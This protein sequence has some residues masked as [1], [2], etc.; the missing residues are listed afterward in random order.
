MPVQLAHGDGERAPLAQFDRDTAAEATEDGFSIRFSERWMGV[1][2]LHGGFVAATLMRTI[3]TIVADPS[4]E[5]LT[6]D[7]AYLAPTHPADAVLVTRVEK[8]GR[9]VTTVTARLLQDSRPVALAV[10]TFTTPREEHVEFCDLPLP[11][12][13]GPEAIPVVGRES[14]GLAPWADNFEMRPSL[15][16][17]AFGSSASALTGGWIKL[18]EDRPVDAA[19]LAALTDA[20]LPS[21][22]TRLGQS[23]GADATIKIGI[24]FSGLASLSASDRYGHCFIQ[25]EAP[26]ARSGYWQ[27]DAT[28]WSRSGTVLVRSRQ[29]AIGA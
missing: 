8:T 18:R 23:H 21:I 20:W 27:E 26:I 7:V 5:A 9:T 16:G 6:L 11:V 22:R 24:H 10:A 17:V 19:L 29:V 1:G 15:G 14:L 4:R 13:I 28:V 2:G 3:A 12:S 25:S